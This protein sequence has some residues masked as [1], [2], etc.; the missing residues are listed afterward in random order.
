[1]EAP[2]DTRPYS[3]DNTGVLTPESSPST[4]STETRDRY[5]KHTPVTPRRETIPATTNTAAQLITPTSSPSTKD[6]FT[7]TTTSSR[8]TPPSPTPAA[9][10][11]RRMPQRWEEQENNSFPTIENVH[12]PLASTQS[13]TTTSDRDHRRREPTTPSPQRHTPPTTT[14]TP[15][16]REEISA[17]FR[18]QKPIDISTL[19]TILAPE[20]G[21]R[22][23][24]ST[25]Q[26]C[27]T[28]KTQGGRRCLRRFRGREGDEDALRDVLAHAIVCFEAL[29]LDPHPRSGAKSR[30]RIV[31]EDGWKAMR[32]HVVGLVEL[33]LCGQ[34][35]K[36]A[37]RQ[38]SALDVRM[39][40]LTRTR[41]PEYHE[42]MVDMVE[43]WIQKIV[44][45]STDIRGLK[46]QLR[47]LPKNSDNDSNATLNSTRKSAAT[48]QPL[49]R[50]FEP[51]QPRSAYMARLQALPPRLAVRQVLRE[52]L[53]E[54]EFDTGF[55]YIYWFVTDPSVVKI[56]V[57]TGDTVERR[58]A[59][60]ADSCGH[61][62]GVCDRL[63]EDW[64][65]VPIN[66]A[67]RVERLVHTEL[68]E[69]RRQL[70]C[71]RCG[72]FHVEWFAVESKTAAAAV[73][74]FAGFMRHEP[75]EY[76]H[77]TQRYQLKNERRIMAL[78][79]DLEKPG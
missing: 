78:V 3:S 41:K 4:K 47:S 54:T 15:E 7:P 51:F 42:A 67:H 57:T 38:I 55:I 71:E 36:L 45:T 13:T 34:H 52:R 69:A 35:A 18:A 8:R 76:N 43:D 23:Q 5:G 46:A 64:L 21:E 53:Q 74:K 1:M 9:P 29:L 75:Y 22:L 30:S 11:S 50:I 68:K 73:R 26:C 62:A 17:Q 32:G 33:G 2:Q 19:H 56:G 79:A 14:S 40:G 28:A 6:I 44:V 66:H 37:K 49:R 59:E 63:R 48:E 20:F 24:A 60:W 39:R 25:T 10:Q 70:W 16:S 77:V 72:Y 65:A 27:G 31:D 61:A 58:L 12:T